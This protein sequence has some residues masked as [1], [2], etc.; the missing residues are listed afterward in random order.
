MS[1]SILTFY[2]ISSSKD[3]DIDVLTSMSKKPTSRLDPIFI[4]YC[5]NIRCD[6]DVVTS[7]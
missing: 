6:I 3:F 4:F 7:I 5:L 1:A 2:S